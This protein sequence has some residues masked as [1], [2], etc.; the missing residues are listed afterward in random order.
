MHAPCERIALMA[1]VC[2]LTWAGGRRRW[3]H[4]RRRPAKRV[5]CEADVGASWGNGSLR[6]KIVFLPDNMC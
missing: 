6:F 3:G 2:G 4:M 1:G 5:C